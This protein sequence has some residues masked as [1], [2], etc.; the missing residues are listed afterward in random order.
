VGKPLSTGWLVDRLAFSPD[1]KLLATATEEGS[2]QLWDVASAEHVGKLPIG[3]GTETTLMTLLFSSDSNM[4]AALTDKAVY[5][6]NVKSRQKLSALNSQL[7]NH[8]EVLAFSA[9]SKLLALAGQE[10][11]IQLL[12]LGSQRTVAELKAKQKD[13]TSL[14][15]SSQSNLLA[16]GGNDGT[17]QL[18]DV[19]SRNPLGDPLKGHPE[20]VTGLA[21][22]PNGKK[23][24]SISGGGTV[25]QWDTDP[26][27]WERKLCA[28]ANRNFFPDEWNKYMKDTPY[29]LT[30]PDLPPSEGV[31]PAK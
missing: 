9:D 17:V 12:D 1:G 20:S 7:G 28:I 10:G 21:F 16:S 31:T 6:W 22:S 27:S 26:D 25:W 4:L 30:C 29:H 14:I 13:I 8:L 23:L 24:V 11:K 2:I 19:A 3:D 5:L 18:W 15:F